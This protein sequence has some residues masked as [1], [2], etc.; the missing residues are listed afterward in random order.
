[1]PEAQGDG[2]DD[3]GDMGYVTF[4]V[5]GILAGIGLTVWGISAL[6]NRRNAANSYS[7]R[8]RL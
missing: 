3:G 8:Y 6:I 4:W 2:W 1:V 7:S 5:L